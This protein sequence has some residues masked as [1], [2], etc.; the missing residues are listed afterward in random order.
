VLVHVARNAGIAQ[1]RSSACV[2]GHIVATKVS[3]QAV[4]YRRG[5]ARKRCGGCT[6]FIEPDGC[7]HV[8]GSIS[9]QGVCDAYESEQGLTSGRFGGRGA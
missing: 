4:N 5:T 2:E 8:A 1:T 3:K 6:M 9:P 7:T